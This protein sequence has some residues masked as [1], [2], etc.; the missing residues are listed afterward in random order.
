MPYAEVDRIA[1]L[2]PN[3]LKITIEDALKAE[4]QL[5]ELYDTSP[6]VKELLDIA[7]RLEGLNRHASTHAAGVIIA[8]EP[9]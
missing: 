8:Q 9:L 3:T 5:K 7:M 4:P 2:I 6:G 1:K